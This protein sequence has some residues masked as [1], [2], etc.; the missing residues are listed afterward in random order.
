M[1]DKFPRL[2]ALCLC[3]LFVSSASADFIDV[4]PQVS[5]FTSFTRGYWFQA[6][7]DFLITG[8][9]VPTDA[10]S[11]NF[12][13]AILRLP[14]APPE[15]PTNTTTFDTLFLQRDNP[16]AGLLNTNILVQAGQYIGILGSRDSTAVNSYGSPDF[17]SSILG[18]PVTLTRF[19]MQAPLRTTLPSAIGVS[20]EAGGN[21]GRVTVQI[22]PVPEP[23]SILSIAIG[24]SVLAFARYRRKH[25]RTA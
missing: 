8:I 15:W 5:T 12:D 16:G 22:A 14:A 19:L 17:A 9:G 23:A 10:S 25:L 11:A 2:S 24:G 6:P 18:F 20:S 1:R 3:L 4:G 13:V 7:T 21:I